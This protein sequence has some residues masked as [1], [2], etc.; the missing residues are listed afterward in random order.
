MNRLQSAVRSLRGPVAL[1]ASFSL[2]INLLVLVP[3]LY[4]LQVYDRI[5]PS[6]NLTTL[7][8]L[9]VVCLGLLVLLGALEWVRSVLLS[10]IASRFDVT[11]APLVHRTAIESRLAQG[12]GADDRAVADLTAIRQFITGKGLVALF[13]APWAPIF[14][15]IVFVFDTWLGA[16]ALG[17]V[18]VLLLLTALADWLA[19]GPSDRSQ[20]AQ[21]RAASLAGNQFRNAEAVV[22]MGM[23]Q[24]VTERWFGVHQQMLIEQASAV[25]RSAAVAAVS[26][27]VRIAL[28]SAVLGVGAFAVIQD[29]ITPGMMIAASILVGRGLAPVEALITH[30]RQFTLVR[31]AYRRLTKLL[32]RGADAAPATTLPRP[33]GHLKLEAITVVPPG[34]AR[35]AVRAVSFEIPVGESLAVVGASGSGKSSLARAVVGLWRPLSGAIRLDGNDVRHWDRDQLGA[36]I[37]YLPQDIELFEGSVSQNIA[38]FSDAAPEDVLEAAR[39]AGVHELIQ[40]LPQG[41]DTPVGS[42]GSAL[43]A[44]QRQRVAL[45]RA[46]FGRPAL[47]VLD[48]PN[49][50]LDEAGDQALSGAI[51]NLKAQGTTVLIITH[52]KSVLEAVDRVL[53][54]REG[55]LVKTGSTQGFS[56]RFLPEMIAAIEERAVQSAGGAPALTDAKP[57]ESIEIK[58]IEPADPLGTAGLL[59]P[60][61]QPESAP[62]P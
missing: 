52:R 3:S 51:A 23:L 41:Y 50:N 39:L 21:Q 5:L 46:V 59:R 8:M 7:L 22:S 57:A 15:G 44:G 10:R 14:I 54:L 43:S 25:E 37:G 19:R 31:L 34:T 36:V 17:G 55:A 28:Q 49:S 38:R 1:V 30:W 62:K 53:A 45:A 33:A 4:M 47:V 2:A 20:L 58:A 12:P 13:D 42:D 11:L 40:R 56:G 18:V 61:T 48:E 16:L 6:R 60:R 35:P 29:R 26:R 9:S 27:T 24:R 32:A